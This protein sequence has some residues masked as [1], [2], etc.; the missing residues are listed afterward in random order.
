MAHKEELV[1]QK[2]HWET[3]QEARQVVKD[4]TQELAYGLEAGVTEAEAH[5]RLKAILES[6]GI[7]QQWHPPKI[8]FGDNTLLNFKDVSDPQTRLHFDEKRQRGA[9]FEDI[10]WTEAAVSSVQ[11]ELL[12]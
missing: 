6:R 9:F 3:Y 12:F 1:G 5:N 11:Q 7:N 2:F 10:L 8:R 4:I